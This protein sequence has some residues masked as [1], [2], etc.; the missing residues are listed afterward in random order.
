MTDYYEF[1]QSLKQGDTYIA[2]VYSR[3]SSSYST[4]KITIDKVSDASIWANGER[5]NRKN[6]DKHGSKNSFLP[7]K[8]TQKEIDDFKCKELKEEAVKLLQT[9]T[10]PKDK[11]YQIVDLLTDV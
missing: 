5:Y 1:L 2:A 4:H 7:P 6:G 11:L 10:V 9:R 8:A 3:Y